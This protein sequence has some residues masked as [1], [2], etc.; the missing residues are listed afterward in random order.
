MPV[1]YNSINI[2]SGRSGSD[3]VSNALTFYYQSSSFTSVASGAIATFQTTVL[4]SSPS[5]V[6]GQ[7]D[8]LLSTSSS[9]QSRGSSIA[10]FS[11]SG[12]NNEPRVGIG[13]EENEIVKKTFEIQ[14]KENS[15]T[16]TEIVLK[17][18]RPDLGAEIGDLAGSI[19]F[20]IESSSFNDPFVTGSVTQIDTVILGTGSSDNMTGNLRIHASPEWVEIMQ[21][22][23]EFGYRHR[24]GAGNDS[25]A[26]LYV[27]G[28]LIVGGENSSQ[29]DLSPLEIYGRQTPSQQSPTSQVIY[30]GSEFH[31]LS[32]SLHVGSGSIFL[33]STY[34]D[35]AADIEFVNYRGQGPIK[36]GHVSG[37][38]GTIGI[39]FYSGASNS[40]RLDVNGNFRIGAST[41]AIN[42][43]LEI[44]GNISASGDLTTHTIQNIE[45]TLTSNSATTVDTFAT[46]TYKG[47]IYDY[48]LYDVGVGARTGQFM[49]IQDNNNVEFTD[50]STPTLG[51]ETVIP[52]ITSTHDGDDVE[53]II[54]NGDGYTFKSMVKKL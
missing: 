11:Y 50:V 15:S 30:S 48:I 54:T 2:V 45:V 31:L 9:L 12:S 32:G 27:S 51:T 25:S 46:A 10:R 52:T 44:E 42:N 7:L 18:G 39:D 37:G 6:S 41:S 1:N 35:T 13:F 28:A 14:S 29:G 20:V 3:A 5:G 21:P 43:K 16:G 17:S 23:A 53:I 34:G 24:T 4:E 49:V 8:I 22:V 36:L 26:M 33:G 40:A 19:T 47:A 38:G